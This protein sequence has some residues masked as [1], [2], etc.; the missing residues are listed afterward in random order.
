MARFLIH[1]I[2]RHQPICVDVPFLDA[3]E[4]AIQATRAKFI[5]CDMTSADEDGV[6]R[7]VMISTQRIECVIQLG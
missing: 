1:L 2:G 6:C 7:R 4:F 5:V 3:D